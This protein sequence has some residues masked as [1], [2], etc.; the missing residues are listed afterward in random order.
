MANQSLP[1]GSAANGSTAALV[2]PAGTPDPVISKGGPTMN[3]ETLTYV[4]SKDCASGAR[5]HT[6]LDAG[7]YY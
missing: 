5:K 1:G 2:R 4:L 3:P 6:A 7:K